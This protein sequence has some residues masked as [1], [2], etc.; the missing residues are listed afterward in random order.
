MST[1][2]ATVNSVVDYISKHSK[3]IPITELRRRLISSG[4]PVELVDEATLQ[5][6]IGYIV[7]IATGGSCRSTCQYGL[8]L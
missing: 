2:S 5:V 3:H 1:S 8:S 4:Q 6:A 7:Q